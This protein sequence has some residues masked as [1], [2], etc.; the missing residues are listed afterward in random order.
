MRSQTAGKLL[1]F[2]LFAAAVVVGG[3]W[4][5]RE[6]RE[7]RHKIEDLK[8]NLRVPTAP[9]TPKPPPALLTA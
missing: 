6:F 5:R 3:L 8:S 4:V 2:L 1:A 9:P 7:M